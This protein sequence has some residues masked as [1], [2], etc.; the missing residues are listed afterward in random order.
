MNILEISESTL[1][2]L[3]GCLAGALDARIGSRWII[4]VYMDMEAGK[5]TLEYIHKLEQRVRLFW[6]QGETPPRI[7]DYLPAPTQETAG[8]IL[9]NPN[10]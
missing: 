6:P 9:P 7:A 1:P 4:E 8:L 10:P 5:L 3:A 2:F